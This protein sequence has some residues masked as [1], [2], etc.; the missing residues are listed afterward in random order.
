[1]GEFGQVF[2]DV[3]LDSSFCSGPHVESFEN[4]FANFIG[5]SNAIGVNSGTS[6]LHLALLACDI[7]P[8]DEVIAPAM[9]FLATVSAIKY[10]GATPVLVD[11]EKDTYCINPELIEEAI[12][13]KTKAII[14]VHLYGHAANVRAI[15][16]IA[17]KYNLVIIEDAAQA[18]GAS[19]EGI[20]CGK[21]GDIAAFS[22]YPGKNL[23][24]CGEA[25]AVVTDDQV[26]ADKVRAMRDWGQIDK[27]NHHYEGF[28]YRMDG[29][30]GAFLG[31]KLKHLKKWTSSRIDIAQQYKESLN[32]VENIILPQ[33]RKDCI[34]VF[35]IFAILVSQRD[36]ILERMKAIGIHC[37]IHYPVSI[38]LHRNMYDLGYSLGDFP[39]AEMIAS[40]ELS[41]PL[42]PYLSES[43][44]D[45][46]TK[47]LKVEMIH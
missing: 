4:D 47:S 11:V 12:T 42:H 5:S 38:H 6:A 3:M 30:Q 26:K 44:I 17:Q 22:F 39:V 25:G 31:I 28:N 45:Y 7:G 29:L 24:A 41:L 20:K 2:R 8:G 18:H 46:I 43:V 13:E 36:Q 15:R 9:T 35:H 14:V 40:K 10:S 23:G 37:G 1:M 16:K 33:T 21:L 34:H 27:G 19:M 32:G